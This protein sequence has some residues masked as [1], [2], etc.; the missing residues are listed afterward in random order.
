MGALI[1]RTTRLIASP[2]SMIAG[3]G[4]LLLFSGFSVCMFDMD[5][6]DAC[7]DL[8]EE[9]VEEIRVAGGEVLAWA[10]AIIGEIMDRNGLSVPQHPMGGGNEL[11]PVAAPGHNG[12][13][14]GLRANPSV[15]SNPS[16]VSLQ[17]ATTPHK[18]LELQRSLSVQQPSGFTGHGGGVS[19]FATQPTLRP[20]SAARPLNPAGGG[21]GGGGM[22]G[23]G[24][25]MGG[26]GG[27]MGR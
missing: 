27:A 11:A 13:A 21:M 22:G 8:A 15:R 12:S 24:S 3:T 10:G 7:V 9:V 20:P 1:A 2:K 23:G 17:Q 14:A 16:A 25:P 6:T 4:I 5:K 19:H 26:G 18:G